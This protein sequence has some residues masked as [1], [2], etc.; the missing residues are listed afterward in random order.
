[1][2]NIVIEEIVNNITL[3]IDEVVSTY[4]IEVSE[5]Q[6]PGADGKSAYQSAIDGGFVGT[7]LEFNEF[8]SE[9]GTF[10][11]IS[12]L[13]TKLNISD[14]ND[15]FKG[16]YLTESAL[17]AAYPTATAGDQAQV[18]EI[19]ATDVVNYSWDAE[20]NIWIN[21][22]TG[23]SGA[24]NTDALPEGTSN[25]YFTSSRV[26]S[27]LLSGISFLTGTAITATDSILI[28]LGKL[29]KQI[30]DNNSNVVKNIIVDTATGTPIT[31]TTAEAVL[32]S[33]L[34]P[35][36][37]FKN[38]GFF[39]IKMARIGKVGTA[40]TIRQRVKIN[41]VNNVST[42]TYITDNLAGATILNIIT[43]RSFSI[44]SNNLKG[45]LAVGAQISNDLSNNI[46]AITSYSFDPTIDNYIFVVGTLGNSA[47]SMFFSSILITN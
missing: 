29:Q 14:Y 2:P 24:V 27:T 13:D 44:E 47:D 46:G 28:A 21:N 39:N 36:N 12:E 8:L 38:G 41:T 5:M 1:M 25:L 35:A 4:T 15:R 32:F 31:G 45:L 6:V 34:I 33:A 23:G 11:T 7:E 10:A 37:S 17:I 40:G 43:T 42:A 26:L 18:N 30:T 20:E 19:G 9:I 3:N 16:V 22:G